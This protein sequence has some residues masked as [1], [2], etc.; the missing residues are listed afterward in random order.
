MRRL[1]NSFSLLLSF[2]CLAFTL[3]H[4]YLFIF[5]CRVYRTK[6]THTMLYTHSHAFPFPKQVYQVRSMLPRNA[7]S[8]PVCPSVPAIIAI[9]SLFVLLLLLP[10]IYC[11]LHGDMCAQHNS[12]S[13]GIHAENEYIRTI[14]YVLRLL[15]PRNLCESMFGLV[16]FGL[17]YA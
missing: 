8:V 5:M 12:R 15:D 2:P 17:T 11:W 4:I 10:L 9:I 7:L 1:L 16:W 6:Y 13:H 3:A 14:L